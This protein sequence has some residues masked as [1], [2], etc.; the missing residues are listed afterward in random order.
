MSRTPAVSAG[1]RTCGARLA[2][3]A[4]GVTVVCS[5]AVGLAQ[6]Q[7]GPIVV[8]ST[9][10]AP[11]FHVDIPTGVFNFDY[12]YEH[13]TNRQQGITTGTTDNRYQETVNLL[14]NAYI[15][16]PNLANINLG[17]TVGFQ[18]ESFEGPGEKQYTN[19]WLYGWDVSSTFLQDEGAPLTAYTRRTEQFITPDFSPSLDSI[20]TTYGGALDIH[21]DSVPTQLQVYQENDVQTQAGGMTNYQLTEDVV[22]WH[23]DVV[24]LK[25]QTLAWDYTYQNTSEQEEDS[26][27]IHYENHNASLN[28]VAYFGTQNASSL[29]SSASLTDQIG[30]L[31]YTQFRLD[32]NLRVQHSSEFQ[33]HYDYTLDQSNISGINQLDNQLDV[34][35]V[36][37]LFESLTTTGDVGGSLLNETGGAEVEQ[38]FGKLDFNYRK[39]VPYG[40]LLS[41]LDLGWQWLYSPEGTSETP[42]INQPETFNNT[43]PIVLTQ[44]NIDP[45]SIVVLSSAGVPYLKGTDF[46]VNTI[47]NLIQIERIVGGLIPPDGGVLLDYDLLP[48]PANTTNTGNLGIGSRYEI[49]KGPLKGLAP[50]VRY[51]VQEQTIDTQEPAQIIPDSY[52]DVVAGMDYRIWKFTFNAEQ[53]WHDSTLVPFNASRLSA[54]FDERLDRDTT[55]GITGNYAYLDYYGEQ[56]YVNDASISAVLDHK[57]GDAW[58]IVARAIWLNDR[59]ELFGNTEGLEE[60]LELRWKHNQTDIYGR[61]RNATLRTSNVESTFQVF[62]IGLTRRF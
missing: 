36:H 30:E 56:D 44:T 51:G 32:E 43:Q 13:D 1:R 23:T 61:I 46:S 28:D 11:P 6:D 45:S 47:G 50:Y 7:G 55:A 17:G 19:G 16:S 35:F 54:R 5:A 15:L 42:I 22:H 8:G 52:T 53:Q 39:R 31:S 58:S 26:P 4:L 27:G 34:G 21:S 24:D 57:I 38:L 33:T 62:E 2:A 20:D 41:N 48:Q 3:L 10:S 25:N 9:E 18:Q 59:D 12:L 14:T 29:S 40:V 49:E 37:H 60:Q